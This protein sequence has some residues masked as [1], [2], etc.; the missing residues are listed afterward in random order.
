LF[1]GVLSGNKNL[2]FKRLL[3]CGIY[4]RTPLCEEYNGKSFG[5]RPFQGSYNTVEFYVLF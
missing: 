2:K 3:F 5:E 1:D 4:N